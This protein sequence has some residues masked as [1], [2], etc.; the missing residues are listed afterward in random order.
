MR[1][2][3][4]AQG[5]NG[6]SKLY[7]PIS[8]RVLTRA[9][10]LDQ[11]RKVKNPSKT[12]AAGSRWHQTTCDSRGCLEIK[13]I[14]KGRPQISGIINLNS[15]WHSTA[16]LYS[17]WISWLIRPY[18]PNLTTKA[19]LGI[20]WQAK[21]VLPISEIPQRWSQVKSR[22]KSFQL[23]NFF[24]HSLLGKTFWLFFCDCSLLCMFHHP[25]PGHHQSKSL[26]SVGTE[27]N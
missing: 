2:G 10:G 12:S 24:P 14:L 11:R 19:C 16:Q 5:R 18:L 17:C 7:M 1:K 8:A 15:L 4:R 25:Q 6:L 9:F 20:E 26:A 21:A 3:Q 23:A 22:P 27:Q 13:S